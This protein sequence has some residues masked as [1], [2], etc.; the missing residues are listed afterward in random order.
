M[1]ADKSSLARVKIKFPD[2]LWISEIFRKFPDVRM[3]IAHFLP[4]DLEKS[5]GNSIIE[6]MYYNIDIIIEAIRNHPSVFE[7]SVLEKEENK[8]R[9]NVKT[10][11]PFLL[12]A[13]IK[14]GVLIDFPIRVEEG[15]AFWRL[16]SSRQ[17]I[18][19]LLSIFEEKKIDF[20]LLRI[21]N[22]PYKIE[23]DKNSLTLD[24]LNILD[25]AISLG[26]FEIPR[27]ISLE[28][29][30]NQ[31]GKSKSA[32]SVMLRKIIKKKVLLKK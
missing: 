25:R 28:E 18:D 4:Y 1:A 2:Q 21:G 19:Q 7:F 23:N 12:Y 10:K 20:E 3:E 8:T 5:I 30:A 22:S 24:E 26:F 31:L 11:D 9:V 6:L 15:Y 16:I 13:I 32:L 17:R 27:K 29:L 14:C